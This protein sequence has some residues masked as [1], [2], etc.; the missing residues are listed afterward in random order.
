MDRSYNQK[1]ENQRKN[2]VKIFLTVQRSKEQ[3][4]KANPPA[5]SQTM[6]TI[7]NSNFETS[8]IFIK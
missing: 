2:D 4:S 5:E 7:M 6:N 3:R 1:I 8:H